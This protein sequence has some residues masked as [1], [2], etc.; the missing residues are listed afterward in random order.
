MIADSPLY[1]GMRA[2]LTAHLREKGIFDENV[3]Q[4]MQT[5]PRHYF[6]PFSLIAYA[7]ED[8]ALPIA[9]QQTISQPYTVAHQSTL[10]SV[11][12]NMKILEIGTGSGYQSAILKTMGAMVYTIERHRQLY[13]ETKQLFSTLKL[14]IATKLGDGY[15]GWAEFA[16]FDRIIVTCGAATL[17][18]KLLTQLKTGGIMICPVGEKTQE[19]TK[20]I[21]IDDKNFETTTHGDCNFVPML[22][23]TE[24]QSH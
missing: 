15:A 20:I 2:K 3:L 6:V 24:H 7:Y 1:Q 19:M 13:E 14:N 22:S 16:P 18:E 8:Q 5:M 4:A 9:C 23:K 21:K 12:P 10:L 17:P 11:K